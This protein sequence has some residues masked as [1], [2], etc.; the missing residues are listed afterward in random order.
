[1]FICSII[2]LGLGIGYYLLNGVHPYTR[3]ANHVHITSA[4]SNL[5]TTT[6]IMNENDEPVTESST[7]TTDPDPRTLSINT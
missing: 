7:A 3:S 4:N 2:Y 6:D 5:T 1:L